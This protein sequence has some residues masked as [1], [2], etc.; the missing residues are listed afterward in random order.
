MNAFTHPK[1]TKPRA[2]AILEFALALPVLLLLLYG[3]LETG[4]LLFVYGSTVTAARQAARYGS[5]TGMYDNGTPLDETDDVPYYN[6]CAGIIAAANKTAFINTFKSV[7]IS[8]DAGPDPAN[9]NVGLPLDADQVN[10][11]GSFVPK[12]NSNR[13][14]VTVKSEWIPI[15]NIVPLMERSDTKGNAITSASERSIFQELN[16]YVAPGPEDWEGSLDARADLDSI[17][18]DPEVYGYV[19]EVINYTYYLHNAG[20]SDLIAPTLVDYDPGTITIDCSNVTDPVPPGDSFE[21]YSTYIITQA[22]LDNGSFSHTAYPTG[23]SNDSHTVVITTDALPAISLEKEGVPSATSKVGNTITYTYTITNTGNVTL[24]P[25]F[26]IVDQTETGILP[27]DC[28]GATAIAPGDS[29]PCSN[30]NQVTQEDVDRRT[31]TNTAIASVV[32]DGDTVLSNEA[33]FTVLTPPI[34]LD[35]SQPASVSAPGAVVY[36]VVLRND[37]DYDAT[38]VNIVDTNGKVVTFLTTP[39]PTPCPNTLPANSSFTCYG[40]YTVTQ[41]EIDAGTPIVSSFVA[42][43]NMNS[44]SETSNTVIRA[45][46]FTHLPALSATAIATPSKNPLDA[47]STVDYTY[48]LTNS[49]NVTLV[50]PI[51]VTDTKGTT[52]VCADQSAIAPGATRT[53]TSNPD[54]DVIPA[55]VTLGS[56][57]TTGTATA[58]FSDGTPPDPDTISAAPITL[59]TPIFSGARLKVT[60]TQDKPTATYYPDDLSLVYTYTLT[61]TGGKKLEKPYSVN[62]QITYATIVSGTGSPTPTNGSV[63]NTYC[64]KDSLEPGDWTTCT[65]TINQPILAA[66]IGSSNITLITQSASA[67]VSD[68]S[69]LTVILP[70]NL[71]ATVYSCNYL[72]ADALGGTRDRITWRFT[73]KVGMPLPIKEFNVTWTSAQRLDS[74]RLSN[75]QSTLNKGTLPDY[76]S[77]YKSGGGSLRGPTS[78]A[79]SAFQ[80]TFTFDFSGRT[81]PTGLSIT[82]TFSSPYSSS[83]CTRTKP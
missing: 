75:T 35:A 40:S 45:I 83:S 69:A 55:D 20:L 34:I 66:G 21:C 49:G 25:S 17:V 65:V 39:L 44:V 81:T 47:N 33:E 78:G 13:I 22:D 27:V 16:V 29:T 48:T 80:T 15:V 77:P 68:G 1:K 37:T 70:S 41:A 61:N 53:C 26:S 19:G 52:I 58:S 31:M 74:V 4:R 3:L 54:Y 50:A 32:Y 51:A 2:Q 23:W 76:I 60:V 59:F 43:A 7:T 36:T 63:N 14:S 11:C 67:V 38:S 8:Y 56:I 71:A 62:Y 9:P 79:V 10:T 82:L 18:A 24:G 28:S 57:T 73:N 12:G 5:T 46:N 6:D 30:T 42:T 72:T 64:I